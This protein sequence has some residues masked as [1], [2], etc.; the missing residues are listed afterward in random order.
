VTPEEDD[1]DDTD[2]T[3]KETPAD[4]TAAGK[5]DDGKAGE[6]KEAGDKAAPGKEE[7][8]KPAAADDA[9]VKAF[10]DKITAPFKANGRDMKVENADEAI[11]LMQMGSNYH[12]KM[13]ALRPNLQLMKSLET[14]GLL[15]QEKID[16]LIDVMAKKPEAI[17]KLVQDSGIDPLD[18]SPEKAGDYKPT[19]YKVDDRTLALDEVLSELEGSKGFDRTVD[20]VANKW[21]KGSKE[22]IAEHPGLL[23]VLNNHIEVGVYDLVMAEV[24]GE[25]TFNRLTGLSDLEAYRQVGN[26]MAESGEFEHLMGKATPSS[27]QTAPAKVVADTKPKQADDSNRREKRKAASPTRTAAPSSKLPADFNPLSM[28]DDELMKLDISKFR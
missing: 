4:D 18:I 12:K 21:D 17:S 20:I 11:Q 5:V 7:V 16:F 27:Q 28:S 19:S 23:K 3:K 9:A 8:T 10:Y 14:A 13:Q 26:A 2:A 24:E 6:N 15:S 1:E 25:R 22:I